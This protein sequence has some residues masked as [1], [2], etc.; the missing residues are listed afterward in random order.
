MQILAS[1]TVSKEVVLRL[2]DMQSELNPSESYASEVCAVCGSAKRAH[3]AF[4]MTDF[5]AL[6]WWQRRPLQVGPSDPLFAE[7]FAASLSFL[8]LHT[9]RARA[10]GSRAGEWGYRSDDDLRAAGYRRCEQDPAGCTCRAP[11]CGSRILWYWTPQLTKMP[12]DYAT[13]QPHRVTC[14]NPDY[15]SR[16]RSEHPPRRKRKQCRA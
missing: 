10:Y 14:A 12:L 6:T 8:R 5:L 4:C 3:S 13:L 11:G 2:I 7:T 9:E 1:V 16:A 15:F